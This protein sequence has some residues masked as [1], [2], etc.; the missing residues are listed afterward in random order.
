MRKSHGIALLWEIRTLRANVHPPNNHCNIAST[1]HDLFT[2]C[3]RDV[4]NRL[5]FLRTRKRLG[6]SF[7]LLIRVRVREAGVEMRLE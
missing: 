3:A 4:P 1:L 7:T 6:F 5:L 2:D